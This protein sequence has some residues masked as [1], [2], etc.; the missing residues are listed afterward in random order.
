MT[1]WWQH[2][3]QQ[4]LSLLKT[5]C[6]LSQLF[7]P[8]SMISDSADVSK[9]MTS[10]ELIQ[11]NWVKQIN[12]GTSNKPKGWKCFTYWFKFDKQ[13]LATVQIQ[14]ISI[15]SWWK[16]LITCI[17]QNLLRSGTCPEIQG[18]LHVKE[19]SRKTWKKVYFFLR[20]S[21][22]YCSTKGSS[23][24]SESTPVYRSTVSV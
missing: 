6:F 18:F 10:A 22:L 9:G 24:V 13:H 19:S 17:L 2:R 15:L 21:G 4:K 16:M 5:L 14:F 7:F 3:Q 23:K 20:R 12:S 11:V 1:M 8:E